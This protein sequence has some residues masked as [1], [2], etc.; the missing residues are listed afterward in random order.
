MEGAM[1]LYVMRHAE[2]SEANDTLQDNEDKPAAFPGYLVPG[3]KRATSVK[4]AFPRHE[5]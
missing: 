3:R 1:I 5:V 4:K 2:A